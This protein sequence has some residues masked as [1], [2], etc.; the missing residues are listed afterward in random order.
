MGRIAV[1]GEPDDFTVDG[2]A[3]RFG[4]LEIFKDQRAGAF[5]NHQT[6]S[7]FIERRGV[8]AGSSLRWLVAKRVSNTA[9][10][11]G[12]SS[13]APPATITVW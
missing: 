9:A 4:M 5:A 3:A 7:L 10:S 11:E 13:S 1:S 8:R 12:Q 2:C 6:I